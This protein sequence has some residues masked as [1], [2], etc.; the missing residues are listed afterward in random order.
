VRRA[1]V[2]LL[3][4]DAE[5]TPHDVCRSECPWRETFYWRQ[6]VAFRAL[7]IRTVFV[8][9]FDEVDEGKAIYKVTISPPVGKHF[10]TYEDLPSDYYLRLTA[11]ATQMIRG[12]APHSETIP[13]SLPG[14][15]D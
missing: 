9:M 3:A 2:Q 15:K 1:I 4:A 10:V 7:G 8:G 6:F 11:A 5:L 13:T 12:D 14:P